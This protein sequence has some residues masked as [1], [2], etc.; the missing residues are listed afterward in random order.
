MKCIEWHKTDI[1]LQITQETIKD[2][3]TLIS[4]KT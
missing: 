1:H 3:R 2:N 4:H